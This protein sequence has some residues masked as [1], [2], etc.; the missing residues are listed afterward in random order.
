[1]KT[2]KFNV[3]EAQAF[4]NY[5]PPKMG[6][7][8]IKGSEAFNGEALRKITQKVAPS[9]GIIKKTIPPKVNNIPNLEIISKTEPFNG[10]VPGQPDP[11]NNINKI[12]IVSSIIVG[13]GLVWYLVDRY[14][15]K[16]NEENR[17]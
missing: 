6:I 11:K 7:N 12:L 4:H 5:Q 10:L 9:I 8:S 1:M 16:K 2:I 15:K 3:L 13:A 17:K 14:R